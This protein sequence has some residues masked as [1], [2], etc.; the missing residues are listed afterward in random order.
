VTVLRCELLVVLLSEAAVAAAS[1]LLLT[2]SKVPALR[3][4]YF[5]STLLVK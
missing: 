1:C 5:A 2:S 4:H 3:V